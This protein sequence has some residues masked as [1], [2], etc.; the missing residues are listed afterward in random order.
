MKHELESHNGRAIVIGGSISGLLAARI[1]SNFYKKVIILERDDLSTDGPH[2]RGVPQGRHAHA[3][4]AG[5]LQVIENLFPGISNDLLS[6]GA[7]AADALNGGVWFFEGA[8][9]SKAR[10][11]T[12][13]I[14]T[15]R[16]LLESVIRKHVRR[17]EHVEIRE[18]QSVRELLSYDGRVTGVATES[19]P[20]RADLVV[21]A[22]GRASHA[23]K[24]LSD[25]GFM[26]PREERVEVQLVYTT[27]L[28]RPGKS[29]IGNDDKFAV[30]APTPDGKRGGV[31]SQQ[32][33]GEWIVTL[34]GHFG[35]MAPP[36]LDGF[37]NFAKSLPSPIIFD[38]ICGA[39]PIDDAVHFRFPA[40][41]RRRYENLKQFPQGFL[42]FGDA[43]CS[44]NPI[45]GQ[46]MS[47]AALQA[48]ALR[49]TLRTGLLDVGPRF[50]KSA[51]KVID[52]PWKIAVGSDL[53]MPETIGPR[54]TSVRIINSYITG[55]H[56]LAHSEPA[57]ALAFI[58]VAQ[59]LKSPSSLMRPG[60]VARV[61][62]GNLRR[63]FL[64]RGELRE[65]LLNTVEPKRR[66]HN[67]GF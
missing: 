19:G 39:E 11:D 9:L 23:L 5:G 54:S 14:M 29:R 57:A 63:R 66:V 21:D 34:F 55:V 43:I 36:D 27:R 52:N 8:P 24:W 26:P 22:S 13:G 10:S 12:K 51:A 30:I 44:F 38:A 53:K 67:D 25:L 49:E 20:I 18:R 7:V 1:L 61:I 46:G 2:R 16:S 65:N 62:L 59:L 41:R 42:V 56:K 40:S 37:L 32:E 28:F 48:N 3:L 47:A 4:L 15:S 35:H 31:I 17:L 45:Y 64:S 58:R 60:L 50:F 6:A 33:N